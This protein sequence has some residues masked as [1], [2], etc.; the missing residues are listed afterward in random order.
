MQIN[1]SYRLKNK[2]NKWKVADERNAIWP[3]VI[4]NYTSEVGVIT[5]NLQGLIDN[6]YNKRG[7]NR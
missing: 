6:Y 4:C 2:K 7:R 5:S 3:R 1:W